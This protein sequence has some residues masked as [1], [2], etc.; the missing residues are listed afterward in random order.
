MWLNVLLSSNIPVQ[1]LVAD[2]I[3]DS[4]P[5]AKQLFCIAQLPNDAIHIQTQDGEYT[6]NT[7]SS[8]PHFLATSN[9]GWYSLTETPFSKK[10]QIGQTSLEMEL[11]R[12]F[13]LLRNI[14]AKGVLLFLLIQLKPYGA[15]K[16]KYLLATE[17]KQFERTIRGF[18]DSLLNI[19]QSDKIILQNIAKGNSAVHQE[20]TDTKRQLTLQN[21]NYEV[22]ISQFIQLIVNKLQEKYGIEIRMSREFIDDLKNYNRP[23]DQ[24]EDNLEK[25]VQIELNLALVQGETEI[26]LTPTHLT[27]LQAA[28]AAIAYASEDELN[29]GRYAKTYKLL[30]R[31][32]AAAQVAQQRG[33]NIIGKHIGASCTPA[34][35]NASIT[36]ALNKHAKKMFELFG[37]FP[38]RWTLIRNEFRSVANIIEKETTRR[39]NIA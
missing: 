9:T 38:N 33:L 11:D 3:S 16:D 23:F 37:R 15:S 18:V 39:Q 19:Q 17:K 31:Y 24:L 36:D 5:Q 25:H 1:Q 34:V 10:Q 12:D 20:I 7:P 22:A 6:K 32:E 28:K 8:L 14:E 30:D 21:Q 26:L 27:N 13:L 2:F 29:L 4:L 35:S